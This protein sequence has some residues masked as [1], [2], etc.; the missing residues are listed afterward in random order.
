MT[1]N[2][3]RVLHATVG[4]TKVFQI[5]PPGNQKQSKG[6]L[7]YYKSLPWINGILLLNCPILVS[8]FQNY[9][10]F[11]EEL[12]LCRFHRSMFLTEMK[13][14]CLAELCILRKWLPFVLM[15]V[16]FISTLALA[17]RIN[18]TIR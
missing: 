3:L 10:E 12:S 9:L 1:H 7:L 11:L 15:L 14:K 2:K 4:M 5:Q 17:L 13:I 18:A 8:L 6:L 16:V